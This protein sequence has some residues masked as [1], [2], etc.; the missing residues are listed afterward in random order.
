MGGI[1]P[2]LFL[3]GFQKQAAKSD[4]NQPT[5]MK[6]TKFLAAGIGIAIAAGSAQTAFATAIALT[7]GG[8]ET[9][10]VATDGLSEM[11]PTGWTNAAVGLLFVGDGS[12]LL[13][14]ASGHSSDQYFLAANGGAVA[15]RQD[16]SLLWSSLSVGDT[17]TIGA[18]TTYRSEID[19]DTNI[20]Y[21]WLN[22][23]DGSGLNSGA[24]APGGGGFNVTTAGLL[25]GGAAVAAGE[26]TFREWTYTITAPVLAN[27]TDGTP[28]GAV[29]V[30]VGYA[31]ASG[32][33]QIA[34]DDVSL[35]Y[36]AV[37]EPSGFAL[38]GAGLGVALLRR[39]R[40]A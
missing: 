27:A 31:G 11:L 12:A 36:V 19:V 38:C 39:K 7:N 8:F 10:V 28:W 21:F 4:K 26:W 2:L 23:G 25:G 37:P 18:W 1:V 33:R 13:G 35:N 16:T 30:Q 14:I 17:L 9:D 32:T 40:R 5:N 6:K 29:E 20:A 24:A 22:D 15:I 34:F 3:V